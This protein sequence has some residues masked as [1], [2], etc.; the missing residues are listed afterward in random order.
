MLRELEAARPGAGGVPEGAAKADAHLLD[1]ARKDL[2]AFI[3]RLFTHFG[4]RFRGSC[5]SVRTVQILTA[6]GW[7][8]VAER[9]VP[10]CPSALR[11]ALGIKDMATAAARD[12]AERFAARSGKA[13]A[14]CAA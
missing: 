2:L 4:T 6:V 11:A 3:G 10:K 9:Y 14:C 12:A 7:A 1:A 5:H 13:S 8:E